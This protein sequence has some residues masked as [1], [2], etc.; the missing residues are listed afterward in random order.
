VAAGHAR[1]ATPKSIANTAALQTVTMHYVEALQLASAATQLIA[2]ALNFSFDGAVEISVPSVGNASR[3]FYRRKRARS[4]P[5]Y[6]SRSVA[7]TG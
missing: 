5:R 1:C 4:G 6:R 2:R 3:Q 7:G